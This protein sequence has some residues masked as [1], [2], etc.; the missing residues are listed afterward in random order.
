MMLLQTLLVALIVALCSGYVLWTLLLPAA[1]KARVVQVLLRWPLPAG[2]RE[3]VR[4][5]AATPAG[6]CAGCAKAA[7]PRAPGAAQPAQVVRRRQ[8]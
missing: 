4:H 8:R 2:L 6:G 5:W 3:R 1:A 7:P